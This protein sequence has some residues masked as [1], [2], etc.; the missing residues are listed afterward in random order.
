MKKVFEFLV[1]NWNQITRERP[2][3]S[4]RTQS[5]QSQ[6]AFIQHFCLLTGKSS[7]DSS[8]WTRKESVHSVFSSW[9]RCGWDPYAN[10]CCFPS[11]KVAATTCCQPL[12]QDSLGLDKNS[13]SLSWKRLMKKEDKEF[14]QLTLIHTQTWKSEV[15]SQI[16]A[17]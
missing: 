5:L 16:V 13:Q 8:W 9:F 2:A 17:C 15:C 12:C 7:H 14:T 10:A 11:P 3:A 6:Q 4:V 1:D